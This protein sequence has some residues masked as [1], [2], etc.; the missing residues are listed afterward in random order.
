MVVVWVLV[1][2]PVMV[3]AATAIEMLS[4][5]LPDDDALRIRGLALEE[6]AITGVIMRKG[7]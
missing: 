4:V 6:A 3:D 7:E 1:P 5:H 2:S